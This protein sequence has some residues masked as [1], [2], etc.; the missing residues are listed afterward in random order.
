MFFHSHVSALKIFAWL[1]S[2]CTYSCINANLQC[3]YIIFFTTVSF[4]IS[5]LRCLILRHRIECRYTLVW[6]DLSGNSKNRDFDHIEVFS[7]DTFLNRAFLK[8]EDFHP[9]SNLCFLA[10]TCTIHNNDWYTDIMLCW[11]KVEK[12]LIL[13]IVKSI[14]STY[15]RFYFLLIEDLISYNKSS[16][17][18]FPELNLTASFA[19]IIARWKSAFLNHTYALP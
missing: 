8:S 2:C 14:S 12:I 13:T 9:K 17:F 18:L 6:I 4:W 10:N 16:Y 11:S 3:S 7:M 15:N 19:S 5:R 1:Q